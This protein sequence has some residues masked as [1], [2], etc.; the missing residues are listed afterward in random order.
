MI[1]IYLKKKVFLR[2][3]FILFFLIIFDHA[4]TSEK[5]RIIKKVN[6]KIIT[7]IDIEN[8]YNYLIALN[9]NL[10]NLDKNEINKIAEE[11]LIREKIKNDEI[12]KFISLEKFKETDL[13]SNII[14]NIF[15]SLNIEN[16]SAFENYLKQYDINIQEVKR[17]ISIEVAWNQM[18][19]NK[20]KN[21]VNIN[22]DKLKER[23]SR[24]KKNFDQVIE[25]N[26][27]EIVFQAKNEKELLLK[28]NQ[29]EELI[30]KSNFKTAANKFS[31]SDTS[32]LGGLVGN[33]KETQLSD[34]IRNELK[35]IEENE[36]TKPINVGGSFMI[37]FI[38]KKKLIDE[39][40]DEE[41]IL[42]S[43]IEFERKKQFE[44]F[45]QI[46]FNKIKLNTQINDL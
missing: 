22:E 42:S 43:L 7:N 2:L 13:I 11:S 33:I 17:K 24:D 23:I 39:K 26:L 14:K 32:K 45:S 36:F 5:I 12:K 27:S 8:E 31:I 44:N 28:S 35:K 15:T 6:D 30:E 25:Y 34:L 9:N 1:N 18:I 46:Y 3:V 10:K 41:Q 16:I 19:A 40:L 20:Y 4:Y 29:I 21:Q 38:N 37:L